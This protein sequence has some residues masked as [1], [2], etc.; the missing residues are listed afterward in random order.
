MC[1]FA[2]NSYQF[3]IFFA[4]IIEFSLEIKTFNLPLQHKDTFE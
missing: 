1:A 4:N 2:V 3:F